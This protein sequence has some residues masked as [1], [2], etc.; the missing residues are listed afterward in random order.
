MKVGLRRAWERRG[1]GR[2]GF[3]SA[4]AQSTRATSRA[5]G[6]AEGV[7]VCC[8]RT[9]DTPTARAADATRTRGCK[10]RKE[11]CH[12]RAD[13]RAAGGAFYKRSGVGQHMVATDAQVS[14]TCVLGLSWVHV[15]CAC[16][17]VL[18]ACA[19]WP[20]ARTDYTVERT[21]PV[22]QIQ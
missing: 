13:A 22:S 6:Q 2:S 7:C 8:V 18:C 14:E 11:R 16:C 19:V 4:P 9:E 1:R 21:C 5:S 17:C 20:G 3:C 10:G 15:L 12:V